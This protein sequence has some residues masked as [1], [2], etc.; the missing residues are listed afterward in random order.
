MQQWPGCKYWI[1]NLLLPFRPRPFPVTVGSGI[2]PCK[3][4]SLQS[5]HALPVIFMSMHFRIL[6]V[7]SVVAVLVS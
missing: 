7:P 6:V 4:L 2:G 3:N 5:L 1:K